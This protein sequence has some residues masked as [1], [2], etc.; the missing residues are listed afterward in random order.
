MYGKKIFVSIFSFAALLLST[1][2]LYA[3]DK[4][5]IPLG[6]PKYK[7]TSIVVHA[8]T[9]YEKDLFDVIKS[10]FN[11]NH[12]SDKVDSISTKPVFTIVPAVGY[13]LQT[14]LA[15][16][17]SGNVAFRT[18]PNARI[19][20][21]TTNP[22]YT[23]KKQIIVSLQSNIWTKNN[24]YDFIGDF[25][26]YK[27]PQSSYGLGTNSDLANENPLVYSFFRF[28]ETV[29]RHIGGNFYMGLGYIYDNRWNMSEKGQ[30]NGGVSDYE[31]YGPISKSVS[32]GLTFNALFDSRDNS[33]NSSRGF[34][35]QVQYRDN[36]TFLGST[37][38]WSSLIVDIRKYY[39][40]PASS[41]NV[42]AFW[43]Y[44]WVVIHGR[45]AYL[46]LPS[47]G[48]DPNAT[49]GRGY[50]QGRFRGAQ[51]VYLESE[52][53]FKISRNGLLGG[54]VFANAQSFSAAPGTP[55]QTIQPGFGPGLRIKLNKVSK[56]NIA[57]DYGFGREG[58]RGLFIN[59]GEV[60]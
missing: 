60:F 56:T 14:D 21:I 43:S 55:L 42:I 49:T 45:P 4:R 10:V 54:V 6:R 33:I 12:N 19:S 28:Y 57:L 52:Y 53:R 13:T 35:T 38:A 44:N 50:I 48:H 58:S 23:Q 3:Q 16:T 59:V 51:M 9:T 39:K 41:D 1:V 34:Y 31:R 15:G 7:D 18:G 8:D 25:R 32:T 27:Y 11:K 5:Y 20:T 17:L 40:F 2:T 37:S 29:L 46:D 26:F 24:K 47:T 22:A 30:L 36:Y